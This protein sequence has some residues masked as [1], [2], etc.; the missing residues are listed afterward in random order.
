M[1][2]EL[3]DDFA[4]LA[5]EIAAIRRCPRHGEFVTYVWLKTMLSSEEENSFFIVK[6]PYKEILNVWVK[7]QEMERR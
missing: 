4:V 5:S 6:K 2:V 3:T 7:A 1:I